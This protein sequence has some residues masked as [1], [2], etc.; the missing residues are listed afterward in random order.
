MP[1]QDQPVVE[2][3][4]FLAPLPKP[5]PTP[6]PEPDET[7]SLPGG[8]AWVYYA[9][10][11]QGLVRPVILAD[12]FNSGPSDLNELWDGLERGDFPFISRL[13]QR[14]RTLVL[15]GYD[16]R[17][18]SILRNAE[19]VTAA[20][21]RTGAEQVGDTRLLV[22]GF[23]MGGLVT[24]YALAKLELQRVDHRV[25]VYLS[26]DS[27]HHGAWVPIALQ[28]LAHFLTSVP[29]LSDQINSPASRQLLWRHVESVGAE[30]RVDPLREE[31]LAE[32]DRVGNWPRIP[33]L[34]GVANGVG[35]G[36]GNGVPA[37]ESALSVEGGWFTGTD[38]RT[39]S[40]GEADVARLKGLLNEHE[41]T[42]SGLPELDGAPGGT[43]ETFGIAGDKLKVTGKVTITHR[44]V[45][46][47]PTVSAV[48][49]GDL[50]DPYAVV[51]NL[52]PESSELDDFLVASKNEP[53]TKITAELGEWILDRLPD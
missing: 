41:I 10:G 24:R 14:G 32:L 9:E 2:P 6:A 53:H 35:S 23:S 5:I 51:D 43:L 21:L 15:I 25:G 28:N 26:Y 30:P 38:L 17:S 34:L 37:G 16:E 31:F 33:R 18:E 29:A 7:W 50:D 42:T 52:A 27:P 8:T 13:R 3:F 4:G 40:A 1:E 45:G 49:I 48:A 36:E 20:I 46:F 39:Q 12:G 11:Q 47:V 44:T 22:G 19:A